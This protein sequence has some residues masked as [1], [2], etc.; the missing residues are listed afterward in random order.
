[1]KEFKIENP[2][3]IPPKSKDKI[4]MAMNCSE[5]F[6]GVA[7]SEDGKQ[8][9]CVCFYDYELKKWG[10]VGTIGKKN[11]IEYYIEK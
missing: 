2:E 3:K 11:L 8:R 7:E 6:F 9:K 4:L 10:F 5:L 1:M